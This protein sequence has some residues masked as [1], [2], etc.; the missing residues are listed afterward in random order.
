LDG[1]IVGSCVIHDIAVV[2]INGY[3]RNLQAAELVDSDKIR[4]G[5]RVYAIGNPFGLAS[6]PSATS[7]VI[8]AI[9]RTI[10]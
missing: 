1:T 7:E 8:S 10:E 6:G 3:N 4:V 2:K 9:N 5:E